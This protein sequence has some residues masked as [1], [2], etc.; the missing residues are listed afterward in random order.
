MKP[1]SLILDD[2]KCSKSLI[3]ILEQTAIKYP[4][5]LEDCGEC[6]TNER[7]VLTKAKKELTDYA[8]HNKQN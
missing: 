8:L 1:L 5:M 6:I 7:N 3:A 4:S 2:L